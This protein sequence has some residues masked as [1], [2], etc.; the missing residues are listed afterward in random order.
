MGIVNYDNQLDQALSCS[1]NGSWC[2]LGEKTTNT[3]THAHREIYRIIHEL[4]F[5][6]KRVEEDQG[7]VQPYRHLL[8][9]FQ[10][11]DFRFLQKNINIHWDYP[12]VI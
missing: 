4:F 2:L 12:L 8:I 7:L 3:H 9:K 10:P 6:Q 5:L 1:I 11:D